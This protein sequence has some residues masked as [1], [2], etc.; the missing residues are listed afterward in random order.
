MENWHW[1]LLVLAKLKEAMTFYCF[2]KEGEI[3]AQR[4]CHIF[5]IFSDISSFVRHVILNNVELVFL[6]VSNTC[7][8]SSCDKS[9]RLNR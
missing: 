1:D 2:A 9:E 5:I 8:K 6:Q 3:L 4:F 7:K